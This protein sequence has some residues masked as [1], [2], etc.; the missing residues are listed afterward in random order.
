MANSRIVPILSLLNTISSS[1]VE[2]ITSD[3]NHCLHTLANQHKA[4]VPTKR[5]VTKTRTELR[6]K[7]PFI[8]LSQVDLVVYAC[9]F[10]LASLK[11]PY[12]L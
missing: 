10:V 2:N 5:S 3:T 7:S 6:A 12:F 11:K 4:K 9:T 8:F 1:Y